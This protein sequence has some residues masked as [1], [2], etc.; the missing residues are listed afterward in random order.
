MSSPF[1][2]PPR[3]I[4]LK[5]NHTPRNNATVIALYILAIIAIA[6]RIAARLKVQHANVLADDW[7]IGVALIPIT[8]NL[9]CTIMGGSYGLGK[10]VWVVELDDV[11]VVMQAWPATPGR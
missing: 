5:E 1:G 11:I 7:L 2:G 10:H 9:V 4:D 3:G 8:A 6:L